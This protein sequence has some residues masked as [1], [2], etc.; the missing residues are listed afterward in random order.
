MRVPV[1]LSD[2]TEFGLLRIKL[3]IVNV[4]SPTQV[5]ETAEQKSNQWPPLV[6][7]RP[8]EVFRNQCLILDQCVWREVVHM[9]P[10][11]KRANDL[12]KFTE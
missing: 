12:G 4:R 8:S 2:Q 5:L 6:Q 7:M 10:A 9:H 11:D 3:G 1:Q